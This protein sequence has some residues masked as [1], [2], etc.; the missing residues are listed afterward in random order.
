MTEMRVKVTEIALDDTWETYS[1]LTAEVLLDGVK[2]Q[3]RGEFDEITGGWSVDLRNLDTGEPCQWT[4]DSDP[5]DGYYDDVEEHLRETFDRVLTA[6]S[7]AEDKQVAIIL[8][9]GWQEI[10]V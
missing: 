10:P 5:L 4:D 1:Y 6:R 2:Y 9:E 8:A 7:I 3:A